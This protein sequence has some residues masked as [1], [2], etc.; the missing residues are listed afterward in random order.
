MSKKF[1]L[2]FLAMTFSVLANSGGYSGD[3]LR[4]GDYA[5]DL[6]WER[7]IVQGDNIGIS[8][9]IHSCGSESSFVCLVVEGVGIEL[10][11]PKSAEQG[12]KWYFDGRIYRLAMASNGELLIISRYGDSYMSAASGPD[13]NRINIIKVKDDRL[14]EFVTYEESPKFSEQVRWKSS[15]TEGIALTPSLSGTNTLKIGKELVE[16]CIKVSSLN[17]LSR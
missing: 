7:G 6:D 5:I 1:Y 14:Q 16:V 2:F 4:S 3:I 12:D 17:C 13:I 9:N 10:A 8:L 11:Y 15:T